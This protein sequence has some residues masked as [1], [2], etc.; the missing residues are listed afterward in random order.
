M[1]QGAID[2]VLAYKQDEAEDGQE[3]TEDVVVTQLSAGQ[4]CLACTRCV[5]QQ[6]IKYGNGD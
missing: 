2:L 3:A 4:V 6:Q 1:V 5:H